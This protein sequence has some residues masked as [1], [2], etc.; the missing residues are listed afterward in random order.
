[1]EKQTTEELVKRV[2][3]SLEALVLLSEHTRRSL[4]QELGLGSAG[5]SKILNGT[6]RLQLSHV[7]LIAEALGVDPGQFFR[8]AVPPRGE[9]SA[10]IARARGGEPLHGV[11]DAQEFDEMLKQSFARLLGLQAA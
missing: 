9:P 3:A 8:W 2:T 4:E 10:L 6:V 11:A 5:I 7:F 1:M